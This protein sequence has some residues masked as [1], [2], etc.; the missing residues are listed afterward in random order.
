MLLSL[1]T[2]VSAADT[3]SVTDLRCEDLVD[4]LGIDVATPRL[5][6]RMQADHKHL[7]NAQGKPYGSG[8][9]VTYML[10]LAGGIVPDELKDDVFAGFVRTLKEQ[11]EG[12]LSTGLSGTYM[13]V[14][15]LQSI[16]RDDRPH[17]RKLDC[18]HLCARYRRE[19][20]DGQ[21]QSCGLCAACQLDI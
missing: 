2:V 1:A 17:P 14:Q 20:G 16:G 11:N 12:H 3:F 13:M 6:W 9:Q 8:A 18:D 21:W 19:A 4:P 15:Y 7:F 5:S 10:P